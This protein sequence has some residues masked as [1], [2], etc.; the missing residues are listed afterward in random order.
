[1]A[2]EKMTHLI[3]GL[4]EDDVCNFWL[5][6]NVIYGYEKKLIYEKRT[7]VIYGYE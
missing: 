2:Y 5:M 1:M 3:Y 4:W 7:Y 6:S